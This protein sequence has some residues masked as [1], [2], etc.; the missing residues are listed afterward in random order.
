[1]E[2]R[3]IQLNTVDSTNNVIQ[4]I[5]VQDNELVVVTAR[6]QTNG[7]GQKGN[8]WEAAD[9][10]NLLM[11]MA[12]R[13]GFIPIERQFLLS[14]ALSLSIRD[15]LCYYIADKEHIY[16]KWPNDI[17]YKD[18]K[19]CGFLVTCDIEGNQTGRCIIGI[20]LNI[21]QT[22][23][24][25]N[26][27]NPVSL[28]QIIHKETKVDEVRTKLL[29]NILNHFSQLGKKH[30]AQIETLYFQHLYHRNGFFDY[31]DKNGKFKAEIT[32]VSPQGILCLRDENCQERRYA[33]KE[34][35]QLIT[36]E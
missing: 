20:G 21:N 19:I 12:F 22:E 32:S 3:Y 36:P 6:F 26:A 7:Y 14:Q 18:R 10:Q 33:F 30:Y 8:H 1:M 2:V 5:P 34:V 35:T 11:S 23:F 31:K 27:P 4:K 29:Q 25:S 24:T 15:T 28:R 17:Y 13:A 9:G 16:I